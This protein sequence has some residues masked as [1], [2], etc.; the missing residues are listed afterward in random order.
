M[1]GIGVHRTLSDG[2]VPGRLRSK[3]V[4]AFL[5]NCKRAK[6]SPWVH[7]SIAPFVEEA[8]AA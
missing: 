1:G 6:G 8:M 5:V 3:G 2:G 4:G 7:R